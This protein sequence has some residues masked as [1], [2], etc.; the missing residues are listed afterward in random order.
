MYPSKV[1]EV[2]FCL[3]NSYFFLFYKIS[4]FWSVLPLELQK[5]HNRKT[6]P[7]KINKNFGLRMSTGANADF[8]SEIGH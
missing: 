7:K 8:F 6:L 1:I 3:K 5:K 4:N 2:Y